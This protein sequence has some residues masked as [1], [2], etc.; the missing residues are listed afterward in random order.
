MNRLFPQMHIPE[1]LAL[2]FLGTFARCEYALN[3]NSSVV[4]PFRNQV[5]ASAS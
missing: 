1:R 3:L 4:T 2:E 5:D